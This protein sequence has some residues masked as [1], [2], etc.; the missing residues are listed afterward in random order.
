MLTHSNFPAGRI[1][2]NGLGGNAGDGL[3]ITTSF[4][5]F[6][7]FQIIVSPP[8]VFGGSRPLAPGESINFFK[9]VPQDKLHPSLRD[10]FYIPSKYDI[11][12]KN[13]VIIKISFGEKTFEKEYLI[14]K[15]KTEIV[16]KMINLI[17]NTKDKVKISTSK[18]K[19]IA[20]RVL[21]KIKNLKTTF[22]NHK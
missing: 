16:I 1:I 4:H 17:N 12:P 3:V 11:R 20:T 22:K 10:S 19:H 18:I 2:T 21:L 5:L 14:L 15:E 7:N 13:H 6:V 8:T 9:E